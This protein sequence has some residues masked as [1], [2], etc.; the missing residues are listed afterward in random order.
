MARKT[1]TVT[2]IIDDLTGEQLD[3]RTRPTELT[4]RGT[5]YSLDLGAESR[6]KLDEALRPFLKAA[7]SSSGGASR[8]RRARGRASSDT[9][10]IREWAVAQG[11]V[12]AGSRGRLSKEVLEAYAAR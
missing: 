12:A 1:E 3:A 11:L 9:A 2:T 10:A 7:S 5:T 8:P 6:R 4:Y